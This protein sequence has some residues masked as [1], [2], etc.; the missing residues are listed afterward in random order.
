[1]SEL[2][3]RVAD[4]LGFGGARQAEGWL[5]PD[6]LCVEVPLRQA[7]CYA[8]PKTL[9]K[10]QPHSQDAQHAIMSVLAHVHMLRLRL[11]AF[12]AYKCIHMHTAPCCA[13]HGPLVPYRTHLLVDDGYDERV[14][15][16]LHEL[17]GQCVIARTSRHAR[18]R[19]DVTGVPVHAQEQGLNGPHGRAAVCRQVQTADS[20]PREGRSALQEA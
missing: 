2:H 18:E 3:E 14:V 8:R 15:H 1:M 12:Y 11:C 16:I 6:G 9:H 7:A 20:E 13:L 19:V 17:D 10:H 5:E 4:C